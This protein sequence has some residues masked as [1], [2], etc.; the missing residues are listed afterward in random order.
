M[1]PAPVFRFR[2][3]ARVLATL[4]AC[5]SSFL[6]VR[7]ASAQPLEDADQTG[8]VAE[9]Y[10]GKQIAVIVGAS[11]GGGYDY[12]ARLMA[13]HLG[14]HIPGQP[15][16]VVKNVPAA[17]SLVAAN[18]LYNRLPQDGTTIGLLIRNMLL[19]PITNPGGVR[20]SL[21][22]FNWLGSLASETAVSVAWQTAP[23]KSFDD[24][25][26]KQ[27]IVGGMTGVDPETTPR[28][29]NA[30]L[31]TKFKIVNGYKGTFDISLAME[32]GEVEGI[33]DWSWASLIS[34]KREWVK[35]RQVNVLLQGALAKDPDLGGIP[36]A[37]DYAKSDFDRQVLTL[38]LSQKEAARPVVAP[39]G[40][41]ADR[42][43]ALRDAFMKMSRDP[44]FLAD[45]E[46]S[47]LLVNPSSGAAVQRIA[48]MIAAAPNDV[49]QRLVSILSGTPQ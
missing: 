20:F 2:L 30:L 9:F 45:A 3:N 39:P 5:L 13:R 27:L 44:E 14:K 41:P 43:K 8:Q 36:F 23:V 12:L 40:V 49:V 32:R 4:L 24:L 26:Q 46:K 37:L 22:K 38:Y 1:R 33:G 10:K 17:N 7:A 34:T 18:D 29:Y 25:L 15:Q 48:S 31:G 6:I 16:L 47:Q 21:E 19:A 11:N 28:I 42:L 35:N